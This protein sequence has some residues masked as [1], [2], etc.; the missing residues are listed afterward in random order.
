VSY[1]ANLRSKN[2]KRTVTDGGYIGND[3]EGSGCERFEVLLRH[4]PGGTVE[5]KEN[6]E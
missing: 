1:W 5:I 3:L 2:I 4:F 6:S